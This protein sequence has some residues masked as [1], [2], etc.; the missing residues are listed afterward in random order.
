MRR[1]VFVGNL[2]HRASEEQLSKFF[3][4]AGTIR[5]VQIARTPDGE[6]RGCAV[7]EFDTEENAEIAIDVFDGRQL[8]GRTLTVRAFRE[9]QPAAV[10]ERQG[11]TSGVRGD[12]GHRHYPLHGR[13]RR[14]ELHAKAREEWRSLR[15]TKRR[16]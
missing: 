16:V 3:E 10:S 9:A 11:A 2:N 13:H 8:L 6:S 7:I 4:L 5:R 15:G 12:N 1:K 14:G